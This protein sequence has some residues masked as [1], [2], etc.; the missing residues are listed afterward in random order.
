MSIMQTVGLHNIAKVD[1][2]PSFREGVLEYV[3]FKFYDADREDDAEC[4]EI[5]VWTTRKGED[6]GKLDVLLEGERVG[7][8]SPTPFD[9]SGDK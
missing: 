1:I 7:L 2:V 6:K 4:D 9:Y 8:I 3:D 5:T